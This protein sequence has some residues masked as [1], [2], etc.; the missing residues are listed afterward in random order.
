MKK[1]IFSVLILINSLA[2]MGQNVQREID[3]LS[4][5]LERHAFRDTARVAL[6]NGIAYA[7]HTTDPVKGLEKAKQAISLAARL[8]DSRGLA[9]GYSRMGINYWAAGEDSLAMAANEKALVWYKKSGDLLSYAKALNNRALNYYALENYTAAIHDHEKALEMFRRLNHKEGI[10]NSYNNMGVVFLALNDYPRALQAFLNANRSAAQDASPLQAS[11]YTNIGLV[12]K[13]L[14]EYPEALSYQK[15]ALKKYQALGDQQGIAS[16]LGNLATVYDFLHDTKRALSLYKQG[17]VINESIGNKERIA[18]D[19]TNIGVLYGNSGNATLAKEYLQKAVSMYRETNDKN[20]LSEAL[21]ALATANEGALS[22]KGLHQVR[23]LQLEALK[24]A[25]AG[26]S[27]LRESEALEALSKTYELAGQPGLALKAYKRHIALRDTIFSKEKEQEILRKQLQFD[28]EQKELV[29]KAEIQ[30]QAMI[31]KA[32]ITGGVGSV[33]IL[34]FGFILYKRKRDAVIRRKEAEYKASVAETELKVLRAQMNPHF[35]F[36]SLNAINDY[37]S[38]SDKE[39]AQ[40][41]LVEFAGLM[42]QAL[43]NSH[44]SEIPL[45]DDLAFIEQYLHIEA[46]R[47]NNAFSFEINV[48]PSIDTENVLIPPLLLQPFIENSIW[49]GITPKGNGNKGIIRIVIKK[50][51]DMLVCSVE[52]NGVGKIRAMSSNTK[53]RKSMGLELT[54]SRLALLNRDKDAVGNLQ[55]S[56]HSNGEGTQVRLSVP[57]KLAF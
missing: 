1:T 27:P 40:L 10:E 6:L 43:E 30:R 39:T 46:R 15:L 32:A 14:K 47:I 48:D 25:E 50:D 57:L 54:E 52:D 42:R 16:T 18:S 22:S 11:I 20:N 19:L 36:N 5:L 29:T 37:I 7:Y 12:Y 44:L 34:L 26:G 55:F 56:E 17:L 9:M 38:K 8:E 35:I 23:E 2:A 21:L 13:N 28:F 51:N 45:A 3:S 31:R 41:Y 24:A 49:H 33:A 4:L 53:K